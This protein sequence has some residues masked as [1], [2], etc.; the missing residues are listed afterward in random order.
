MRALQLPITPFKNFSFGIP[1]ICQPLTT[2]LWDITHSR[3][4]IQAVKRHQVDP[5]DIL[6]DSLTEEH[7]LQ[8]M[9]KGAANIQKPLGNLRESS[10]GG[11]IWFEL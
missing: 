1:D 4:Y 6:I 8:M 9:V 11:L 2:N 7:F 10:E 5:A 3:T